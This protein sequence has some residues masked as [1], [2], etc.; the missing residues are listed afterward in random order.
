MKKK[1]IVKILWIVAGTL[2]LLLGVGF[3]YIMLV[4]PNIPVPDLK[5]QADSA[6]LANGKY[7]AN[8]VM[9]CIDCHS[10]RDWTKFSGPLVLGTEGMGGEKFDNSLGFPGTFYA[11]N[12]TPFGLKDWSDGEIYRAIT[13]G[14]SRDRH[15]LF[16]VMPYM[17]YGTMDS[18]DIYD[19]IAY[20][21]TLPSITNVIPESNADFPMGIILHMIPKKA[22]PITKPP[23]ADVDKY[24]EYL[25]N[26][27]GCID[28]H[29]IFIDGKYDLKKA[30]AGGR[31]FNL[32]FGII[33]SAN[34]TPDGLTGIG[35]WKTSV[36]V[37]RFKAYDMTINPLT[38]VG[39]RDF[40]SLM[41]WS[42]YA[43]MNEDD[44]VSIFRYLITL[45][46]ISNPV[47]KFT[48]LK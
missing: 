46:P 19:V 25:V 15:I 38:T 2:V 7:L 1:K 31:E 48:P 12:I 37:N 40:N 41:P 8:H 24:G 29:T 33:R 47:V 28:C 45:Q 20:I 5:V 3:G 27:G 14:V 30:F 4:M 42:M 13:S 9:V 16:P 10:S 43:G 32:P 26:A 17:N 21:R 35:G 18:R 39:P 11:K 22:Q 23:F 34:I 6:Q 44:L 36:F